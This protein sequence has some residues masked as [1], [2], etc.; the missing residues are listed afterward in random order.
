MGI[1]EKMTLSL[2][3]LN[4]TH[5]LL[6]LEGAHCTIVALYF[7]VKNTV[8]FYQKRLELTCELS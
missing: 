5:V 1:L 3:G 6:G 4:Q 2:G 8:K 7:G